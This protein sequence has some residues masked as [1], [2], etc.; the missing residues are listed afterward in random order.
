MT[1]IVEQIKERLDIVDVISSYIK[2]DK[3][4]INWKAK[5]PFHNEK[6]PSFFISQT[7]QNFFC[8]GCHEK[9]DVISF[10]EKYEGLDFKG[11]LENLANRAGIEIK[12]QDYKKTIENRDKLFE[13]MEQATI[14]FE[15]NLEKEDNIKKYLLDRGLNTKTIKEWRLGYAEDEW[16]ALLTNLEGKGFTKKELLDVGLLKKVLN[17]EKYYDTFR[18]R[19]MFPMFDN[20]NRVIAFSGRTLRKDDKTPKYLNSP[21]TSLFYKS[22]VLYGFNIAKNY[23]RKL[24][25]TVLVEGQMDLIMS[26]Q[27]GVHNTVASSGTALTEIHLK[28]LQRLSNRI[29]IAYD[30]DRAGE[31]AGESAALMATSLG[32]E[33]KIALL[34]EGEDPASLI[35]K[36]SEDW[37]KVLRESSFYSEYILDKA[38][39]MQN[40][41]LTMK[42]VL[43]NVLP[44]ASRI[45]SDI[46]KEKYIKKIASKL[47]VSEDN[48]WNDLQKIINNEG[49]EE[50]EYN[51]IN[52]NNL[53]NLE[54]IVVGI[55]LL[56]ESTNEDT[57]KLRTELK[58]ILGDDKAE[59][60][61]SKYEDEKDLLIFE[62]EKYNDSK[63]FDDIGKEI[64]QRL[65]LNFLKDETRR[66]AVEMDNK[67]ISKEEYKKIEN[68]FNKIQNRIRELKN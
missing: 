11:A 8:F 43:S 41:N 5:C 59:D 14:F 29:I 18:G 54:R 9:G 56:Q 62:L 27:S 26:H 35:Q 7:R 49:K 68:E 60:I 64:I 16:R 1:S 63:D 52:E 51:I 31:K 32:M 55:I 58:R 65:E 10:V 24:D 67:N 2:V 42:Y 37:K 61:I 21:E 38:T 47:R 12:K 46:E 19:I 3:A 40:E 25:Y 36:S 48:V 23:I 22:E 44:F 28:K 13:A 15:N 6:T 20:A 66:Y 33:V 34:N 50:K 4:G 45:K 53:S 39:S 57:S 30:A 17:E